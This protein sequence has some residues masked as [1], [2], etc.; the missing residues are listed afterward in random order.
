MTQLPYGTILTLEKLEFTGILRG[1]KRNS[2]ITILQ[3]DLFFVTPLVSAEEVDRAPDILDKRVYPNPVHE[4]LT[5]RIKERRASEGEFR[6]TDIQGKVIIEEP[7]RLSAA[8]NVISRRLS[9]MQD[10]IYYASV[11][12]D[13]SSGTVKFVKVNR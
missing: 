2:P 11:T 5:L 10:G 7:M 12:T 6:V 1:V 4:V 9:S 3:K 13:T 8:N